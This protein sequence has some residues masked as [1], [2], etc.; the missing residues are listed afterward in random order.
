MSGAVSESSPRRTP[1]APRVNPQPTNA[2]ANHGRAGAEARNPARNF[3]INRRSPSPK[4]SPTKRA[5]LRKTLNATHPLICFGRKQ[6]GSRRQIALPLAKQ[7]S[8]DQQLRAQ[9]QAVE[10]QAAES[11]CSEYSERSKLLP[12]RPP[13]ARLAETKK[14]KAAKAAAAPAPT[15][16]AG[17]RSSGRYSDRAPQNMAV[18]SNPR[19][20]APPGSG[21]L[22]RAGRAGLIDFSRDA[23]SSW[24]RQSSGVLVDLVDRFRAFRQSLLDRRPRGSRSSHHRR[25]RPLEIA[26]TRLQ[27]TTS[28]GSGLRRLPRQDLELPQHENLSK[29]ATAV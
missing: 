5:R 14:M 17:R 11:K 3:L 2:S 9:M 27:K 18:V 12:A 15:P 22:W 26:L 28:V 21:L 29:L 16:Q 10:V 20:I 4:P 1:F 24:S 19:L 13:S 7:E 6:A 23:G 8:A 25:R